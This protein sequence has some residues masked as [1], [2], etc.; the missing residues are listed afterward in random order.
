MNEED[1]TLAP[2]DEDPKRAGARPAPAD[3]PAEPV[4][5]ES[6]SKDHGAQWRRRQRELGRRRVG[7]YAHRGQRRRSGQARLE[8]QAGR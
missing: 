1:L 7:R 2:L 5:K 4:A 6:A 3:K 8:P